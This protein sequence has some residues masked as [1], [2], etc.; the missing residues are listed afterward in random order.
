MKYNCCDKNLAQKYQLLNCME[1]I[2]VYT[3]ATYSFLPSIF[4]VD[5]IAEG[6]GGGG[7]WEVAILD[8][9][10]DLFGF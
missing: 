1:V 5:G 7:G 9:H 6:G 2:K 4:T 3:T 8:C 10:L